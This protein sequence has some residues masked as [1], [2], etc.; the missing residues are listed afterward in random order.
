MNPLAH[1]PFL[2]MNGIGNE[3]VVLDLRGTGLAVR[4]QDA[5]AIARGE[6]LAYDQLMVLGDPRASGADAF[7]TIFNN[8]GS[9]SASCGNGTRC[10]AWA[11]TRG[12]DRDRLRL[13]T[14][15]GQLDIRRNAERNFTVDMGPPR[16]GWRDIP[17]RDPVED[18]RVVA[19]PDATPEIQALGPFS[20]ASMGNPHAIFWVRDVAAIDVAGLGPQLEHHPLF[21]ARANI[22]FAEVV[23]R[24]HIRLRVWERG[25]GITQA[26]GSAACATLVCAARN[27]LTG[28]SA[29]VSLPGGDL[30]ITWRDDD[31]V[32]MTGDVELEF[33]GNFD[34]ALFAQATV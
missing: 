6:G 23:S 27:G 2:K 8:D 34:P 20:A 17:L 24:D 14:S 5:R 32:L 26:C 11:L 12:S 10:V 25:A 1:R 3:I 29:T 13:E 31:H 22:S 30:V 33:E 7:M 15:A 4:P 21:P 28:R 19:V 9:E 16:L 18:T